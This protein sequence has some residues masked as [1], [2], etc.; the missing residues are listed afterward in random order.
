MQPKPATRRPILVLFLAGIFLFMATASAPALGAPPEPEPERSYYQPLLLDPQRRLD[1]PETNRPAAPQATSEG[2]GWGYSVHQ[3]LNGDNWD[4]FIR[5]GTT[6]IEIPIATS[7]RDEIQ[8]R[9][10]RGGDRVAYI[11]DLES[12]FEV[13]TMNPDG[14][15]KRRLTNG[16]DTYYPNW[17]PDGTRIVFES[18]LPDDETEVF[19]INADGG[20]LTQL[21]YSPGYDGMA[22]WAPDGSHILFV[23]YRTGGYRIWR[24]NPDG[25]NP[26]ILNTT[27]YS[28]HPYYSPD[29]QQIAFDALDNSGFSELYFMNADGS[30]ETRLTNSNEE[31]AI[32]TGWSPDGRKIL[33]TFIDW[34]QVDGYWYWMAAYLRAIEPSDWL[35]ERIETYTTSGLDM[36]MDWQSTDNQ[37]PDLSLL[38][39]RAESGSPVYLHIRGSD[40]GS[41]GLDRYSIQWRQPGGAWQ[42]LVQ[43]APIAEAVSE[44]SGTRGERYEFRVRGQDRGGNFEAW[45]E[46]PDASTRI[47][48]YP[49]HSTFSAAPDFA[50]DQATL[51]YQ[52]SDVGGSAIENY[53]VQRYDSAAGMWTLLA[54]AT[55][56]AQIQVS[57]V[58]GEQVSLRVR[59]RDRAGN[60][61]AW[62]EAGA[63]GYHTVTFYGSAATGTAYAHSGGAI[64]GVLVSM[65]PD[66]L[67]TH[68]NQDLQ[69]QFATYASPSHAFNAVYSKPGYGSLPETRYA[70]GDHRLDLYL[71]PADDLLLDGDFETPLDDPASPWAVSGDFPL[72]TADNPEECHTGWCAAL[73]SVESYLSPP[74]QMFPLETRA[75]LYQARFGSDGRLHVVGS[76]GP[77]IYYRQRTVSGVWLPLEVLVTD[78]PEYLADVVIEGDSSGT[79]HLLYI[80][81]D[82]MFYRQRN[83]EGSWS[84]PQMISGGANAISKGYAEDVLK[85]DPQGG[86]HVLWQCNFDEGVGVSDLCYAHRAPQ[87][88]W[89]A[90]QVIEAGIPYKSPVK[91]QITSSGV[92]HAA[93]VGR[94][95]ELAVVRAAW[96]SSGGAWSVPQDLGEINY[97]NYP[98]LVSTMDKEDRPVLVWHRLHD[99]GSYLNMRWMQADGNWAPLQEQYLADSY[100]P[101]L[102]W[103]KLVFDRQSRL[104]II[105]ISNGQQTIWPRGGQLEQKPPL[106]PNIL[107]VNGLLVD[108]AGRFHLIT[109]RQGIGLSYNVVA[110]GQVLETIDL[111]DD[112][113]FNAQ[114]PIMID[115]DNNAHIF[116]MTQVGYEGMMVSLYH[117]RGPAIAAEEESGALSQTVHIPEALTQAGLSFLYRLSGGEEQGVSSLSAWVDAGSGP[118]EALHILSRSKTWEHA[119]IDLSAYAGQTITLSL[120]MD[121]AAG[122][123]RTY[124]Y[125]DE[126]SL[127]SGYGDSWL[128]AEPVD[129]KVPTG[130]AFALEIAYGNQGGFALPGAVIEVNLPLGLE[131][132]EPPASCAG[133]PPVY[134][135]TLGELAAGAQGALTLSLRATATAPFNQRL[136]LGLRLAT[137][138]NELELLNNQLSVGII[139]VNELYLPS[140]GNW[141]A[142]E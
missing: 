15:D 117:H 24:M 101:D 43:Q 139:P 108:D 8:P 70:G 40:P 134:S 136:E 140:I 48:T 132:L 20:G 14:S 71:P 21:T 105:H 56:D 142:R 13:W 133:G 102:D 34:I 54:E 6:G 124:G 53:D 44:F 85:I 76:F 35:N 29:G 65:E 126:V 58:P 22:S 37:A 64:P 115:Q 135:C 9:L 89:S 16:R 62:P 69:G 110:E 49:P 3:H 42:D 88:S 131:L 31:D 129:R 46:T 81:V 39:L 33:F 138:G 52:A 113:S 111:D 95:G 36:Y 1:T 107:Y 73:S 75:S 119:W 90:P 28:M 25:S 127:G 112:S 7:E 86:L 68:L 66:F 94:S 93:W 97:W 4:I 32:A 125:L 114:Q 83:P 87:G 118:Q 59:A 121:Q 104:H 84:S 109:Q 18:I 99:Y 122:E 5:D 67:V 47:E 78:A 19:V 38:P 23:S 72:A 50:R 41:S 17:S 2:E 57:G 98:L 80:N 60:L 106:L 27:P 11:S 123:V 61:E 55:T 30:G 82:Q 96:R 77:N 51:H 79:A 63:A 103:V 45:P 141:W 100:T 92:L 137:T 26:M 74:E 91:M 128:R 12:G 10:R 130:E 116:E 120:R